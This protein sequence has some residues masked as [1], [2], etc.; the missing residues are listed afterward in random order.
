MPAL[1]SG[2]GGGS[3]FQRACPRGDPVAQAEAMAEPHPAPE[4][5]DE[6]GLRREIGFFGSAFLSFNGVVG[7]G[8]FALPGKLYDKF[9]AFSPFLFP[10]FGLLVL[11][12]ALPF[13]RAAGHHRLSGGPVVYAAVFGR[14]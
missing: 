13:A 10:L 1:K 8:I 12:V 2:I 7:A 5:R 6:P 4:Q 11:L 3:C 14:G 9:G